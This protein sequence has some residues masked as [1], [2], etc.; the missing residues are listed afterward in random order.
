MTFPFQWI[1]GEV[2][3]TFV[4]YIKIT[5]HIETNREGKNR[6]HKAET[7]PFNPTTHSEIC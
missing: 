3:F 2:K 6:M 7:E 1:D 5:P 4:W